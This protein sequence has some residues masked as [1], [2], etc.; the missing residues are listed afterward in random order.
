M[1]IKI[2]KEPIEHIVIDG[3]FSENECRL[4]LSELEKHEDKWYWGKMYNKRDGFVNDPTK[5]VKNIDMYQ[6]LGSQNIVSAL[7]RQTLW[8]DELYDFYRKQKAS[9]IWCTMNYTN[10]DF[11]VINCFEDKCHYDWHGDV[12]IVT[13][14]VFISPNP[15]FEGGDF[16]LTNQ[17]GYDK[18]PHKHFLNGDE[19]K[20][21]TYKFK[22]GRCILFPSKVQHKVTP[23]KTIN[24]ELK[25]TRISIQNRSYIDW[26]PKA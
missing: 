24:N 20:E 10:I 4:I 21:I 16:I 14:N 26:Q 19:R 2:V 17:A 25:N 12:G 22:T 5:K 3:F 6:Q 13:A 23:V 1:E 8:G 11:S 18:S 9:S 7:F 15:T